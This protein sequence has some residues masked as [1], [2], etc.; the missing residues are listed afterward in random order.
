M[1]TQSVILQPIVSEKSYTK[2]ENAEYT[3]RVKDSANKKLVKQEVE[4]R[5]KV[6]VERVNMLNR[7][8]RRT[9]DPRRRVSGVRRGYKKA[10]VKLKSGNTIDLFK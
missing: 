7:R 3:F 2:S 1:N 6:K 5:F 4:G 10:I 8:D 9:L